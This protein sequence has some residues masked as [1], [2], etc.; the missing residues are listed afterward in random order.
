M[1]KNEIWSFIEELGHLGDEWTEEQV[2]DVYGD[3]SYQDAVDDR[4]SDI[5]WFGNIVLEVKSYV[6]SREEP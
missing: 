3:W 5:A 6:S 2:N 1:N 4:K